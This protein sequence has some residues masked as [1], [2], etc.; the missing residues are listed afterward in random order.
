MTRTRVGIPH[1]CPLSYRWRQ[2]AERARV[3]NAYLRELTGALRD[4]VNDTEI[5]AAGGF[6]RMVAHTLRLD[7]QVYGRLRAACG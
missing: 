7:R 5:Q 2:L 6:A 3:S 4:P 1:P